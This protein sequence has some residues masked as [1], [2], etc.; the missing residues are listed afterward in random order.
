MK[1]KILKT[2]FLLAAFLTLP[3]FAHAA[4][5]YS[6]PTGT[7][8]VCSSALPCTIKGS[9]AKMVGGDTLILKNGTYTGDNN[10]ISWDL[11]SQPPSGSPGAFTTIQAETDG[12]VTI[13]GQSARTP[14]RLFGSNN[15]ADGNMMNSD[16][17]VHTYPN[18]VS[19]NYIKFQGIIAQNSGGSASGDNWLLYYT[20]HIW[21]EKCGSIDANASSSGFDYWFS[22]YGLIENSYSF[23]SGRYKFASYHSKYIIYRNDVSRFDDSLDVG[24]PVADFMFYNSGFSEGQNLIAVDGDQPSKVTNVEVYAGSFA[25]ANT[26]PAYGGGPTPQKF[27]NVISL[28]NDY[29]FGLAPSQDGAWSQT[30]YFDNAVGWNLRTVGTSGN[31]IQSQGTTQINH[32]T[33]GDMSVDQSD[34][35]G[36]FMNCWA[37]SNGNDCTI[38]N[39]IITGINT[40]NMFYNVQASTDMTYNPQAS[41]NL[42]I[43]GNTITGAMLI[44]G[45]N[46]APS[47]YV[48]TDLTANGTLKY[49]PEVE[50]GA[51]GAT[52]KKQY[53]K[54][55]TFWGD[56][57]YNLLQDGTNGQANVNMWPW[58]NED[59]I[60]TKMQAY[61]NNGVNGNRDFASSTAKQLDGVTPTTLTSY[62]WE[63]LG[64]KMPTSIYGVSPTPLT[65]V[66]PTSGT[67]Q[68]Q[69]ITL[70]CAPGVNP[71]ASTF[72]CWGAS[73]TPTT[74]YSGPIALQTGTLRYYSTDTLNVNEPIESQ[75]Y[76]LDD[77]PPTV[78][79]FTLGAP[80]NLTVP[81]AAFT[82][83]DANG[84]AAYQVTTSSSAPS[85]TDSNWSATKPTSYTF[86]STGNQT[87]YAWAKD[88]A[89]N[90]STSLNANVS[91]TISFIYKNDT[92]LNIDQTYAQTVF[93]I[94]D[95]GNSGG[96]YAQPITLT[97][98]ATIQSLSFYVAPTS[99]SP[100]GNLIL[101]IYD[102]TGTGG[103]PGARK[104]FT[105]S[106]AITSSGWKTL[107][108]TVPTQ[109]AVGNYWIAYQPS[110]D[111]MHFVRAGSGTYKAFTHTY[112]G[113]IPAAFT[114]TGGNSD[115]WSFYATFATASGDST[116]PSA[117][118]G[119]SVQ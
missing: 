11:G 46:P 58:P 82:A 24:D 71:C 98:P 2:F 12:G 40:D 17:S 13:D 28:N 63:Y 117:P 59:L 91:V 22:Q 80:T 67:Y 105:N 73:C 90:V 57:G 4:T 36:G 119:L 3:N 111:N 69:N 97:M 113:T 50:S 31:Q 65:G 108:V 7:G 78:D 5:Y 118:S 88:I 41:S 112:D 75:T 99:V 10:M 66:S 19:A 70:T 42:D 96:I 8:S 74:L 92:T 21:I 110:S 61:N 29:G 34:P 89:G 44:N 51:I 84:V 48:T 100:I 47:E 52:I 15:S 33:F 27:T 6:S 26:L 106:I 16:G 49:L 115:H 54:T 81:I 20:D 9:I 107:N 76:T 68:A 79:T 35:H 45:S 103:G 102:A 1:N 101:G 38:A 72:Y 56:A 104:A 32:A 64:N 37:N 39:S 94:D 30:N 55:G 86:T 60:K 53:G 23:G 62:I 93:S 116:A 87:L 83:S 95:N 25:S 43:Y 114:Q 14:V 77:T 85:S 109:L 18:S